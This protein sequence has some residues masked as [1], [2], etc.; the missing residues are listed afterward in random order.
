MKRFI[1]SDLVS[2]IGLHAAAQGSTQAISFVSGV[3]V[4]RDLSYSGYAQYAIC[5]A[6]V[7]ALLML[8]DSGIAATLMARGA[9]LLDDR[10]R[11]TGSF[12]AALAT[13]WLVSVPIVG[14]G[15]AWAY[16]LLTANRSSQEQAGL[17]V[18]LVLVTVFASLDIGMQQVVQR[19]HLRL[20]VLRVLAIGQALLRLGLIAIGAL[21]GI[22][23][24]GYYL[25]VMAFSA[26]LGAVFMRFASRPYLVRRVP[27][28]RLALPEYRRSLFKTL[29]MI[30]LL[31]AGEQVFLGLISA[32]GSTRTL[33]EFTAL[34]RFGVLFLVLN[35]LVS[36][37]AAPLVA[38]VTGGLRAILLRM[39]SVTAM[40]IV[41]S[42]V[43]IL[44]VWLF[45][46]QILSLLG[47]K[48]EGL[49]TELT[50]VAIGYATY[51]VGYCLDYLT[52]SRSW[53][54]G[55]W[56][57]APLIIAWGLFTAFAVDL[58]DLRQLALAFILQGI[59]LVLTQLVRI[60]VGAISY[61][62]E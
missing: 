61:G 20:D 48:Y 36:D 62:R 37:L 1:R 4:V 32:S 18:A 50:L 58:T 25:G 35:T 16:A 8:T 55:S 7:A 45:S 44:L 42:A 40:Y 13:R 53:L 29:P 52:Q 10:R 3:L 46:P 11:F 39:L 23:D 28:D 60:S 57:Y 54:G 5:T 17:A 2:K 26:V 41:L 43:L 27:M 51:N 15:V 33:S 59:A 22:N 47:V 30:G 56:T 49:E 19:I 38:R 14:G 24:P 12:R 6:V 21:T 9:A 34:S 31:I